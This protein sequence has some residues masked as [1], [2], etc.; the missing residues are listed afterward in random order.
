MSA[1]ISY[2]SDYRSQPDPDEEY[3]RRRVLEDLFGFCDGEKI[4]KA[5]SMAIRSFKMR[6]L[7]LT[8]CVDRAVKCAIGA[9]D[10][11]DPQPPLVA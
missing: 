10:P 5:Q 1:S 8:E 3:I 11:N 4:A 7:P 9:F 2:I 6:S